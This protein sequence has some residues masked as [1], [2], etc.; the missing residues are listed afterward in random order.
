MKNILLLV[1]LVC[2]S[3]PARAEIMGH[4]VTARLGIADRP[5]VMFVTLYNNGPATDIISAESKSFDRIEI[6]TH[7]HNANGMMRMQKINKLPISANG[8]L[9]LKA[10]GHHL[11]LF[12]FRG[13]VGDEVE[14]TVSFA[15]GRTTT[16]T[17]ITE[18]R[19]KRRK[20]MKMN[21]DHS[22]HHSH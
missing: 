12:G 15:D 9:T 6:H 21:G 14:V 19:A 13:A 18:A 5:G 11:M 17:A 22:N 4:D 3:L 2:A 16:L 1:A 7:M 10:G 8:T 20:E